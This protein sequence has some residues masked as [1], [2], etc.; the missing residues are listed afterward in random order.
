MSEAPQ[1]ENPPTRKRST[2]LILALAVIICLY[3]FITGFNAQRAQASKTECITI[4]RRLG[5]AL[6][7]YAQDHDGRFSPP[8]YEVPG[9][10]WRHWAGILQPYLAQDEQLACPLLPMKGAHERFHRY[11]YEV[12]Y[13]LNYRF[14]GAFSPGPFPIEN[15]EMPAQT[16][17]LVESGRFLDPKAGDP[18]GQYYAMSAYYD[19][20]QWPGAY[21][22]P[23][24]SKMNVIAADG[25][26]VTLKLAH[27][28]PE[29]HDPLY[30]RLGGS[31]YNWNGGHPNGDTSGPPRE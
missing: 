17:L 22:S 18:S 15:L 11:S 31:I 5:T 3:L 9:H 23:H 1:K 14:F 26:T 20:S 25:H 24:E 30:G 6:L 7:L 19:I 13:A 2:S 28:K 29:N 21:P 10:D 8:D 12:S 16:V 27:Y 4:E